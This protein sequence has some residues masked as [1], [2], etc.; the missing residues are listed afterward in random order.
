MKK[1]FLCIVIPLA[2]VYGNITFDD[3]DLLL[4]CLLYQTIFWDLIFD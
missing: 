3:I 4:Y 2:Y 1:Y